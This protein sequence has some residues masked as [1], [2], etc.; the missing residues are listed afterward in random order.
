MG[1]TF[2][3]RMAN[4]GML[5]RSP[6][7]AH[8]TSVH[9]RY[10]TR[11]FLKECRSLA[12]NGYDVSLLVADG[13]G[14]EIIDGVAILDVGVLAGRLK[15]MLLATRRIYNKAIALDAAIY[16]LHDPELL[17]VGLKLRR[18]GK[19]VI[20]DAHEDVPKQLLAKKYLG[21]RRLRLLSRVYSRF[22]QY[23]C[24]RIA[25]VVAATPTIRDKFQA[26][27]ARSIV[28][29]NFPLL[30]ELD[31]DASCD[32]DKSFVC[33][34]GAISA[35]RGIREIVDAMGKVQSP[36]RLLLAGIFAEQDTEREVR[37]SPGWGR[38][39]ALG[40]I[41]RTKLRRVLGQSAAGLVTLHP[42]PNHMDAHPIKM[43]EYMSAGIPVIASDIPLWQKIVEEADCG[44]CV[45]PRDSIAIAERID[46]I[47]ANP[48][49]ARRLGANGRRAIEEKYNWPVEEKKLLEFYA[50]LL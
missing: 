39:D 4:I 9:P 11:I 33:Y 37:S 12:S 20:F 42:T 3:E 2:R 19:R 7:I 45:D 40:Y 34:V 23:A 1:F 10:D 24:R 21:P 22:E 28:V 17:P 47:F 46:A 8:L 38:V 25:G 27:N 35:T 30:D 5:D 14:D 26:I 6:K 44:Y 18:R 32:E 50:S 48:A 43:F 36:V 31:I 16:H 13:R 49:E 41:D 15:R 29:N